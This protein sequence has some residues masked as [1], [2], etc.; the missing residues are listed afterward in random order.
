[1]KRVLAIGLA[2]IMAV[3]SGAF[4][5]DLAASISQAVNAAASQARPNAQGQNDNPYF[6]PAIIVMSAGGV[7]ALYGA[8]HE[9]GIQC[10]GSALVVGCGFTKSKTTIF[11]GLGIVGVGAFLFSK[12][13][14]RANSPQIV[15]GADGIRVRQQLRW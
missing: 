14:A 9:T 7:V 1:M 5:G 11:T 15:V 2:V 10:T 13:R 8:T 4:A 3:P 12:G 6:L